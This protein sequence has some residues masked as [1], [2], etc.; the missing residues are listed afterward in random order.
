M[1]IWPFRWR[2]R[3][4][5]YCF[6]WHLQFRRK[7]NA[8]FNREAESFKVVQQALRTFGWPALLADPDLFKPVV[9]LT[10]PR[11]L[12][13]ARDQFVWEN[14]VLLNLMMPLEY[15][16]DTTDLQQNNPL[17]LRVVTPHYEKHLSILYIIIR[18]CFVNDN[19]ELLKSSRRFSFSKI[20]EM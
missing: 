4:E 1:L 9:P 20:S 15:T 18:I 3:K 7:S 5:F 14:I 13:A 6:L 16:Q 19:P 17:T 10:S 2:Q 12:R 8:S 11:G